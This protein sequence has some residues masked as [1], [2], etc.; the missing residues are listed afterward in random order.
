MKGAFIFL[1][2]NADSQVNQSTIEVGEMQL[3][4]IGVGRFDIYPGIGNKSGDE[5]FFT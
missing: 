5:F 3:L 1:A 2:T 4:T